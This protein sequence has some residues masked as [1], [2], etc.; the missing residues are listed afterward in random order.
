MF[1][2]L[3][4]SV[5]IHTDPDILLV[6]EVLAVGDIA[7]QLKCFERMRALKADGTTVLIVSHSMHAIRL[8]CPRALLF[9]HG[10]LD[11]D[12]DAES[13]I[14]RH[15]ELLSIDGHEG[16]AGNGAAVLERALLDPSGAPVHHVDQHTPLEY[17]LRIRLE[18][19]VDSPQLLF[20]V[21]AQD[22]TLAYE[23]KTEIGR[24]H[25]SF[26]PGD[27]IDASIR[28]EPRL[29][30]GTYRLLVA[31]SDVHGRDMLLRETEGMMLYL[32]PPLGTAGIA[33]LRATIALDGAELT[34]HASLL[35]DVRGKDGR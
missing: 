29:G 26:G 15:H 32:A 16:G 34:D 22:G 3:G 27:E 21:V 35:L 17:R 20:Y 11:L 4:F 8:L 23:M 5:A 28:F 33:D 25:R 6:D 7:F 18:R 13:V 30:G 24:T 31:V 12:S 1:M 14:A 10:E 9:R 2:R 19:A